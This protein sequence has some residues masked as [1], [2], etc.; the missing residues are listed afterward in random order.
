MYSNNYEVQR[1]R[2]SHSLSFETL[3]NV[4]AG[5]GRGRCRAGGGGVWTDASAASRDA[6]TSPLNI[7]A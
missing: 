3:P 5:A 4:G 1:K 2:V 6:Q 7:S